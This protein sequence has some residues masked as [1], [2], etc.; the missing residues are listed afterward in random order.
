M[1]PFKEGEIIG[2]GE[3]AGRFVGYGNTQKTIITLRVTASLSGLYI[4]SEVS[5]YNFSDNLK[6]KT[7]SDAEYTHILTSSALAYHE[8]SLKLLKKKNERR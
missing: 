7:L 3:I 4:G 1:K 8:R 5:F 6:F 2:T